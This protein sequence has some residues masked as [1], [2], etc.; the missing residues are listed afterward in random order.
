M[1]RFFISIIF[2]LFVYLPVSSEEVEK[3]V[4]DFRTGS[5]EKFEF[6]LLKGVVNNIQH[7]RNSLKELKVVVVVHGNGY[8][9]FIKNLDKSPYRDDKE[10]KKRQKEFRERLENLVKFYGVKFEICEAGLKA[11]GISIDNL[12]PFVKPVYSALKGIVHWQNLGYAY[13]LFE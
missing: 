8:K 5:I 1:G 10:L 9:F 13:M 12:Y 4:I 11:R 6:Y 7:Y 3:V 2:I